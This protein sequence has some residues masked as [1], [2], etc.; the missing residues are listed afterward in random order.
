MFLSCANVSRMCTLNYFNFI[1]KG[2][3]HSDSSI[4]IPI[5]DKNLKIDLFAYRDLSKVYYRAISFPLDSIFKELKKAKTSAEIE[6]IY[7]KNKIDSRYIS[8]HHGY[9][10]LSKIKLTVLDTNIVVIDSIIHDPN[11]N[12]SGTMFL[13][14]KDIGKTD[15]KT[16]TIDGVFYMSFCNDGKCLIMKN[17]YNENC[18]TKKSFLWF[19]FD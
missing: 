4:S 1:S 12:L 6:A 15:L 10:E 5:L 2:Y 11:E 19:T 17:T 3:I 8:D 9:L 18:V 14:I 7:K 16:E 13:R